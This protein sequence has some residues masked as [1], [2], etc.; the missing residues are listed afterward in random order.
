M[1]STKSMSTGATADFA[2]S[3]SFSKIILPAGV[4]KNIEIISVMA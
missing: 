1:A 3:G 4:Q 2:L